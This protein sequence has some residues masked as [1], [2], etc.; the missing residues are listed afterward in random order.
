MGQRLQ[1]AVN[2]PAGT[3]GV[4]AFPDGQSALTLAAARVRHIAGTK[5]SSKRYMNRGLLKQR[6]R[7]A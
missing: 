2:A 5:W 6:D 1:A 7:V 4:G 3:R